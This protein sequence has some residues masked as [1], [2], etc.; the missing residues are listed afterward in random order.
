MSDRRIR[1]PLTRRVHPIWRGIGFL[2]LILIPLISFGIAGTIMDYLPVQ[3]PNLVRG[4]PQLIDGL[5][6][7]YLQLA[8]TL[9]L[10]LIL[11]L[12]MSILTSI[13]YSALG[14]SEN[15]EIVSR[16]GSGRRR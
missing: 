2:L 3:Y 5:D 7:L 11:Y 12:L 1:G 10:S 13:L 16:I 14:G 8:I 6:D 9:V 4:N 15:E